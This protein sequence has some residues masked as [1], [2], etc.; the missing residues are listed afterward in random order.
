MLTPAPVVQPRWSSGRRGRRERPTTMS[1]SATPTRMRARP[2]RSLAPCGQSD[3]TCASSSTGRS[4][5]S[6]SRGRRRSAGASS[7]AAGSPSCS[8]PTAL[9]REQLLAR[10]PAAGRSCWARRILRISYACPAECTPMTSRSSG[11]PL[12]GS[13]QWPRRG[14]RGAISGGVPRCGPRLRDNA[15]DT[16]LA[17]SFGAG[18]PAQGVRGPGIGSWVPRLIVRAWRHW[19]LVPVHIRPVHLDGATAHSFGLYPDVHP[20]ATA[21]ARTEHGLQDGDRWVRL[22]E[23]ALRRVRA[24]DRRD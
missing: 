12:R 13:S 8:R 7:G 23:T 24:V 17:S 4:S 14:R 2:R 3:R 20:A 11:S 18:Q 21:L 5:R 22:V 10:L 15:R 1:S 9:P 19:R 6:A 16:G